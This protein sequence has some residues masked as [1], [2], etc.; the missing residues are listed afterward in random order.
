M[1]YS[2]YTHIWFQIK[3]CYLRYSSASAADFSL[4]VVLDYCLRQNLCICNPSRSLSIFN[5][6]SNEY[7]GSINQFKVEFNSLFNLD[8]VF[9]CKMLNFEFEAYLQD[10]NSVCINTLLKSY[11]KN[12]QNRAKHERKM[13]ISAFTDLTQIRQTFFGLPFLLAGALL[14]LTQVDI[15]FSFRW[16]WIFPAFM[17]AR[18]S[19][20]AFNQLI[21]RCN[22]AKNPRTEKRVIPTGRVTIKQ[23]RVVAYSA[24]LLF[25]FVCL[26]INTLCFLLAPFVAFLLFI[27]SYL[28]RVTYSCHFV[29]GIIH[30]LCPVMASIALSG[31]I[32][33]AP[34]F[35]GLAAGFLIIGNDII[36]SIQDYEFDCKQNIFSLP[37][38]LGI[39]NSLLVARLVHL[40]CVVMLIFVGL[41]A[42]LPVFYYL[43]IVV[44]TVIFLEFHK[45]VDQKII[46]SSFFFCNVMISFSVFGFI[47]ASVLWDAM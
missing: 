6:K 45:R 42:H 36:Y 39:D 27:Y 38:R 20:M 47:L 41:T 4:A 23:A 32:L 40:L 8:F 24:L 7:T 21:D 46:E 31:T 43:L 2:C 25:F 1:V 9:F 35:L 34:L 18:I 26:Q 15:S 22:D 17:L 30:F 19:G 16:L 29:L 10:H 12:V 5:L 28:K 3:S 14:P 37:T 11:F 33:R 44:A 13:N